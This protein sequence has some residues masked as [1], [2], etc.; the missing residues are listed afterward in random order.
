[1]RPQEHTHDHAQ[2][3]HHI[4]P[5]APVIHEAGGPAPHSHES[6]MTESPTH[7]AS[8]HSGHDKHAGHT[9]GMFRDRFWL[10][11]LLTLPILYFDMHFQGWFGYQAVQF[12]G[13]AWGQP[14]LSSVLYLYGGGGFV[15]E[16]I[17]QLRA[18]Q[19][20]MMTSIGCGIRRA[21]A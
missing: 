21:F 14:L 16:A 8:S 4:G 20:G 13:V 19:P 5:T 1:M 12:P 17:P 18:R 3:G 7:G 11:L 10:S 2:H 6:V 9:P 15:Q